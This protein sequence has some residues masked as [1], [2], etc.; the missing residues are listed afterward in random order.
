MDNRIQTLAMDFKNTLWIAYGD[1]GDDAQGFGVTSYDQKEW[2]HYTQKDGLPS[3]YVYKIRIDD[4][5]R[6]WF[7][8]SNGFSCFDG[9]T[10]KNFSKN[11]I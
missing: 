8:T 6:I 5:N 9:H 10:F 2:K 11:G 3:N 7:A 1:A 4:Q